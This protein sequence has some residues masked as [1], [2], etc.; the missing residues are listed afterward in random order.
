MDVMAF[1]LPWRSSPLTCASLPAVGVWR[2]Q[3]WLTVLDPRVGWRLDTT[4]VRHGDSGSPIFDDEGRLVGIVQGWD[5]KHRLV[6]VPGAYI[7]A[8]LKW[9]GWN[10]GSQG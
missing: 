5:V 10:A 3:R 6:L 9:Y 7:C 1:V 4:D 2:G 8:R